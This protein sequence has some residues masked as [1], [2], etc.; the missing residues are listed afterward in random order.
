MCRRPQTWRDDSLHGITP[1]EWVY[2]VVIDKN[3]PLLS[4]FS[5]LSSEEEK[6]GERSQSF[7][8]K[9]T[10][11]LHLATVDYFAAFPN[12]LTVA[13]FWMFILDVSD[14]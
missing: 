6:G 2:M 13:A 14:L 9:K 10:K 3:C 12:H 11:N 8:K 5:V 1:G 4:D 7:T